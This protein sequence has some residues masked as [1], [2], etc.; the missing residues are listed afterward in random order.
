MIQADFS[1]Q[2]DAAV[3]QQYHLIHA[4]Y[5]L[6]DD[7]DR[8][9]LRQFGLT[10]AQYRV[11]LLL[12]L[13]HGQRLTTLSERLLRAKSTITRIVDQLEHGGLVARS[14]D[15]EDRRAQRVVL[16]PAG[17]DVLR[18]A[19]AVHEEKLVRRFT[20]ALQENEQERFIALL[21]RLHDSLVDS[22]NTLGAPV[23]GPE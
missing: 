13:E 10:L 2:I 12:D 23:T 21:T 18:R 22:L 5:V 17:A 4:I 1:S 9:V 11:L 14:S 19:R 16:T 6:L 7:G 8:R 20:L 15:T 3:Q